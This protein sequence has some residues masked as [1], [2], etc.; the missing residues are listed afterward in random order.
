MLAKTSVI[1]AP[2]L[3]V[4]ALQFRSGDLMFVLRRSAFQNWVLLISIL[5]LCYL[6]M[7]L[8][9]IGYAGKSEFIYFQF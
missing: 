8:F 3:L 5:A 6:G 7:N 9:G 4:Q 1:I 2:L